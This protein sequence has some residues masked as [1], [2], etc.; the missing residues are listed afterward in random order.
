MAISNWGGEVIKQKYEH[1]TKVG[2]KSKSQNLKT[3]TA[4][5]RYRY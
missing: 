4:Y 5:S 1:K 3:P 2:V